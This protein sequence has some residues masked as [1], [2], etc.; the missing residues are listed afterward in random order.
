ML[1]N[2]GGDEKTRAATDLGIIG[3]NLC[4]P[5]PGVKVLYASGAC[6]S[7]LEHLVQDY[8]G[9]Q[10]F[11]IGT[12]HEACRRHAMR[13]LGRLPALPDPPPRT[14]KRMKAGPPPDSQALREAAAEEDDE[15][16]PLE[17]PCINVGTDEE[18]DV[19]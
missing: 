5:Q 9:P 1:V 12:D 10:F 15:D 7:G 14:Y 13:K 11:V 17:G 4:L 16:E 8:S 3:A 19:E 6:A 18:E 2:F